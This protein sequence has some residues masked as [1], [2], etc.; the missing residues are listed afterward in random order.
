MSWNKKSI[1]QL[2]NDDDFLN[3]ILPDIIVHSRGKEILDNL[4]VLAIYETKKK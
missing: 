4:P 1:N 2:P 3:N